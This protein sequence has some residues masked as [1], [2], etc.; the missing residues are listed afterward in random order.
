MLKTRP[1]TPHLHHH[2]RETAMLKQHLSKKRVTSPVGMLSL[3]PGMS[4]VILT[5]PS[6]PKNAMV[7]S[8]F[9]L[10]QRR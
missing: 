10:K 4:G 8:N 9:E 2:L 6:Q 7:Q 5:D 3:S 1:L